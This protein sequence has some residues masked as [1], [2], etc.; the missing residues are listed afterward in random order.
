MVLHGF[1]LPYQTFEAV[2]S[3]V[4]FSVIKMWHLCKS[5]NI[6]NILKLQFCSDLHPKHLDIYC[7]FTFHFFICLFV[8]VFRSYKST[9]FH[10]VSLGG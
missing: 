2:A 8:S 10:S 3:R 1:D 7:A 9:S 4:L 5:K 6:S